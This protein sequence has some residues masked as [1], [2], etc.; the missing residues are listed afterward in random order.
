MPFAPDDAVSFARTG[1]VR[2][3]DP[4]NRWL[5][6]GDTRLSLLPTVSVDDFVPGQRV[7][8]NGYQVRDPAG[9]PGVIWVVTEVRRAP[10]D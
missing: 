6:L 7:I 9:G 4:V 10:M 5:W 1:T 2:A 8:A 3:W